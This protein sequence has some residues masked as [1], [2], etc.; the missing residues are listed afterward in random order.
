MGSNLRSE[1][2]TFAAHGSAPAA[3]RLLFSA[4]ADDPVSSSLDDEAT[5]AGAHRA[6]ETCDTAD[7][8]EA[9]GA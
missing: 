3:T 6:T 4:R 1:R 9:A 7:H 5:E 8:L 2:L